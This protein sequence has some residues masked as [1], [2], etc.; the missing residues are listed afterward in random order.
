MSSRIAASIT[1]NGRVTEPMLA[2]LRLGSRERSHLAGADRHADAVLERRDRTV[3]EGR[4]RARGVVCPVEVDDDIVALAL[5]VHIPAHFVRTLP[6]RPIA[7]V[8]VELIR[9]GLEHARHREPHV[10]PGDPEADPSDA[11]AGPLRRGGRPDRDARSVGLE[12]GAY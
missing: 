2:V 8:D 12:P 10:V 3:I 6:G 11:L 7:E 4:E 1:L 5:D 9:A